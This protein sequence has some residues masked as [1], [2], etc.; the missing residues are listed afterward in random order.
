LRR[1]NCPKIKKMTR[2]KKRKDKSYQKGAGYILAVGIGMSLLSLALIGYSAMVEPAMSRVL[3]LVFAAHTFGG[4]AAGI[5]LCTLNGVSVFW[6]ILYNFYLE[7]LIVCFTYSLFVLSISNHIKL[8]GVKL[9]ALRLE[10]KAR[11]YKEKISKYGWIGLFLF[12]MTPLPVTGPVIGSIIGYLLK[13]KFVKNFSAILLGTLA[14]I[15]VWTLFF[16]FLE[17]HLHVIRYVIAGIIV[18]I[19]LSYINTIRNWLSEK[20]S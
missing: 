3:A 7:V 2:I 13:M 14:A 6:T 4:R 16:D 19:L 20:I 17:Q 9:F 1:T 15:V 11:K 12:V 8:R 10:R 5:S 18:I